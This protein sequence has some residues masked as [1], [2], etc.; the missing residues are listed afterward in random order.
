[1]WGLNLWPRNQ[2]SHALLTEPARRPYMQIFEPALFKGQLYSQL[3]FLKL[4]FLVFIYFWETEHKW[5]RD[6]ERGTEPEAGS[7]LWAVS[8]EPDRVL[9]PVNHEI[10][11][12]AEVS[13][14]TNWATHGPLVYLYF[15]DSGEFCC[16]PV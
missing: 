4:F 2:E 1:M 9:E 12:W 15:K 8:T 10:V 11:T 6:R 13:H 14:S 3:L 16:K 5:G 7:R